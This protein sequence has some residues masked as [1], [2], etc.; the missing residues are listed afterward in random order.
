MKLADYI[1]LVNLDKRIQDMQF[2][3]KYAVG[4]GIFSAHS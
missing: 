2:Y 4:G 3:E 1:D